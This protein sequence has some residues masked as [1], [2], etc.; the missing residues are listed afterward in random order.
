MTP[1]EIHKTLKERYEEALELLKQREAE[2]I[3]NPEDFA[4]KLRFNSFKRH[5]LDLERQLFALEAFE[6]GWDYLNQG[7]N[8]AAKKEFYHA[9]DLVPSYLGFLHN[10]LMANFAPS[11]EWQIAIEAIRMVLEIDPHYQIA[12]INLALA[13]LNA[14]VK[15]AKEGDIDLAT[16]Y[17]MAALNVQ[18]TQEIEATCR[19]NLAA[20]YTDAGI[21]EYREGMQEYSSDNN[22]EKFLIRLN[23]SLTYMFR[24]CAWHSNDTT[25]YNV[26]LAH[27]YLAKFYLL[28]N[29][30]DGT[31]YHLKQAED[32]GLINPELLNEY[33]VALALLGQ[34]EEA[35]W[36]FERALKLY[37]DEK[38]I[39]V[40][41]EIAKHVIRLSHE[42]EIKVQNI[43][44]KDS[45]IEDIEIESTSNIFQFKTKEIY[46][47][48][49]PVLAPEP[50]ALRLAAAA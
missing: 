32:S 9:V 30:P 14:G 28:S 19:A 35:I 39:K 3:S 12:R 15:K 37:P 44:V 7:N 38:I 41:L 22:L 42:K 46:P 6:M 10:Q 34:L 29:K 11:G 49:K 36:T 18:S 5:V 31:A 48:Y 17:F 1:L 13:N 26:G 8:T 40:N 20:S 2:L 16:E 23:K 33:G 50:S 27:V 47:Q 24:A 45:P 25:R 21:R 43:L 4:I